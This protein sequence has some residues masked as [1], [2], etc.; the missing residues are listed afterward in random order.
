VP[1]LRAG[2]ANAAVDLRDGLRVSGRD[3]LRGTFVVAE[4]ALTVVLLTG[5]ALLAQSLAR[6][7]D[8]DKGFETDSVLTFRLATS[9]VKQPTRPQQIA[10]FESV[11]ERVRRIPGVEAAAV[12]SAIPLSGNNTEG[13]VTIEGRT[14]PPG[15]SPVA[16]KRIVSAGYFDALRIP[17][18]RGRVFTAADDARAPGVMVISE[19]FA[20]RWFP[21]EDPIGKRVGFN[22][23]MDGV[24]TVVGVVAN[25][26]HSGLDDPENPAVYVAHPQRAESAFHV[27]VRTSL[28]PESMVPAVRAEVRAVDPDRPLSR[29]Q[30]MD[31]LMSASVSGRRLSLDIVGAFALIGLLLAATGI[32]GVVS[33]AAQQRT[34]EFGI[35]LALGAE[36][37]SVLVLVLGQGLRLAVIGAA[38][39]F[40]GALAMGGTLRA[41]LFGIEP[42]DPATLA[43]VCTGVIAVALVAGYLPARRTVK[44]TPASILREG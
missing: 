11:L 1:A 31:T 18:R 27:V 3:R 7:I 43:A 37:R 5:T 44:I 14:F 6:L 15:Q 40:A 38:L 33:H 4:V 39:G 28:P 20:A 25:V 36:S 17:V 16:Q 13:G 35:R 19:A 26:K 21:G 9:P 34:R 24:Q 41:Q 32:Y 2:R 12:S 42:S 23:D 22:W 10:F 8:V 30:T 29:V